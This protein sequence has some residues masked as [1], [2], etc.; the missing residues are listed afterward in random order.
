MVL[1]GTA[2]MTPL[3]QTNLLGDTGQNTFSVRQ[4]LP[5]GT[6]LETTSAAAEEVEEVLGGTEGVKDVQVT[7]GTSSSASPPSPRAGPRWR[8]SP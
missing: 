7:M 4:E 3:L 2:A 8:P 1:V 5:P 6:S